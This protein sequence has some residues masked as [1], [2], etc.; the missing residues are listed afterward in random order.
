MANPLALISVGDPDARSSIAEA[1]AR[2]GWTVIEHASGF[3]LVRA[4]SELII[5]G[6]AAAHPELVV[7]D[8]I[9][10]GCSGLTIAGGLRDLGIDIRVMLVTARARPPAGASRVT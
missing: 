6:S 1:L 8:A 9:S 5:D 4:L 2:L 3:H 7:V 10:P